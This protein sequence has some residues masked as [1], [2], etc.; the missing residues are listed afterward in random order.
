MNKNQRVPL[1]IG[2][3]AAILTTAVLA[4]LHFSKVNVE[5]SFVF[6]PESVVIDTEVAPKYAQE[7]LREMNERLEPLGLGAPKQVQAPIGYC[8]VKLEGKGLMVPCREGSVVITAWGNLE[9]PRE[10]FTIA[11][12]VHP[13]SKD[14]CTILLPPDFSTDL[15]PMEEEG[16]RRAEFPSQIP[17]IT[18]GH[19]WLHCLGFEHAKTSVFGLKKV[20]A[21]PTGHLMNP[22]LTKSGWG[23]EGISRED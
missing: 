2:S 3:T 16:E 20:F 1:A 9:I 22:D 21:S 23:L 14:W 19:E 8:S 17:S 7:A 6:V 11:R 4:S 5:R 15:E 13:Q 18:L 10:E 12:A